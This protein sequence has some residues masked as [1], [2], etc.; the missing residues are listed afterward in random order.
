MKRF[1]VLLLILGPI[2]CGKDPAIVK[3]EKPRAHREV[4]IETPKKLKAKDEGTSGKKGAGEPEKPKAYTFGDLVTALQ[5]DAKA[6]D[7]QSRGGRLDARDP[8]LFVADARH[9]RLQRI[10]AERYNS[11]NVTLP[12][13]LK[14]REELCKANNYTADDLDKLPLEDVTK[15]FE[16][17]Q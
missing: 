11:P 7:Y 10:L 9:T 15:A 17:S 12:N 13:V 16:E 5:D 8:R 2:G 6:K 3:V 4:P 14:L 1:L